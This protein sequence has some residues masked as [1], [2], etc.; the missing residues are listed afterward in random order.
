MEQ[1][2]LELRGADFD[3]FGQLE[4]TLEGAP[5]D[6]LIKVALLGGI[7]ALAVDTPGLPEPLFG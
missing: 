3:M 7:F 6:A 4:P 1:A 2:V 5:C